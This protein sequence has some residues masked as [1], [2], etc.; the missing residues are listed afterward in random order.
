MTK[1]PALPDRF[2]DVEHLE[3]VMTAP[4]AAL[5]AGLEN[6]P[7]DIIVL[8]VGGKIGPSLAQLARRAAPGKRV[9]GVARFSEKG[10]R[11]KLAGSGIE[12]VEANRP[13]LEALV[14]Y[15]AEQSLIKA[16][17]PVDELFVPV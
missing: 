4:S 13:T 10:L 3:E 16:P 6:L 8:G 5:I 1:S 14:R 11:E 15:M 7:G 2:R 9:L 12:C 17:I